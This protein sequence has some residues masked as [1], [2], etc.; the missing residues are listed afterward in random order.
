MMHPR[1]FAGRSWSDAE[2]RLLRFAGPEQ[3]KGPEDDVTKLR[4]DLEAEKAKSRGYEQQIL[5]MRTRMDSLE[6]TV[7]RVPS[8]MPAL[9][10][11]VS[12]RVAY[13]GAVDHVLTHIDPAPM[14]GYGMRY[15]NGV[16]Y[17]A[18][19]GSSRDSWQQLK[20]MAQVRDNLRRERTARHTW[21]RDQRT[22][23]RFSPNLPM[24]GVSGDEYLGRTFD[25]LDRRHEA[26]RPGFRSPGEGHFAA[27]ALYASAR[28]DYVRV[29]SNSS[30]YIDRTGKDRA[31]YAEFGGD[32]LEA[33]GSYYGVGSGNYGPRGPGGG[34][35]IAYP[36]GY[37]RQ[38]KIDPADYGVRGGDVSWADRGG[39]NYASY[40]YPSRYSPA[41]PGGDMQRYMRTQSRLRESY[42]DDIEGEYMGDLASGKLR[43][44]LGGD[45]GWA[46]LEKAMLRASSQ[47]GRDP[48]RR[49]GD[50][51]ILRSQVGEMNRRDSQRSQ[52]EG[53]IL[54][55]RHAAE[56]Y[57]FK[58]DEA[59]SPSDMPRVEPEVTGVFRSFDLNPQSLFFN[60][61]EK[62]SII[63]PADVLGTQKD[64]A[65]Q[66]DPGVWNGDLSDEQFAALKRGGIAIERHESD[67]ATYAQGSSR[68]PKVEKLTVY[69][70]KSGTFKLNGMP[71]DIPRNPLYKGPKTPGRAAG[72]APQRRGNVPGTFSPSAPRPNEEPVPPTVEVP[73]PGRTPPTV[74]T[75]PP[76]PRVEPE[77]VPPND[78]VFADWLAVNESLLG[79][80][81]MLIL[82][83]KNHAALVASGALPKS[84]TY[85][86]TQP[87][88]LS[89]NGSRWKLGEIPLLQRPG[90]PAVPPRIILEKEGDPLVFSGLDD[91]T[92]LSLPTLTAA[93]TRA[94]QNRASEE[95]DAAGI[96]DFDVAG[97]NEKIGL[98]ELHDSTDPLIKK[99]HAWT[100]GHT[101]MMLKRYKVAAADSIDYATSSP[102]ALTNAVLARYKAGIRNFH[103]NVLAHGNVGGA[104]FGGKVIAP[105]QFRDI[106]VTFPDA[107]FTLNVTSCYGAGLAPMMRQYVD[108]A[109]AAP[110]RVTVFTQSKEDVVNT[111]TNISD[112][113]SISVY[114]AAMSKYLM[115]GVDGRQGK[116]LT[117]GEAHL[118][119]DRDAKL[120]RRNDAEVHTS[121]PGAPSR[122]TAG[123]DGPERGTRT[124]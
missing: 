119:A 94:V 60:R 86:A 21:I 10:D 17:R 92:P 32:P 55:I 24:G 79:P 97:E 16:V 53:M 61:G 112:N 62:T 14:P 45:P 116:R 98:I 23:A 114:D 4:A 118:L 49:Y 13:R 102:G 121:S 76:N 63:I 80:R 34:R 35:S 29:E 108:L 15:E 90:K 100:I 101:L 11:N 31:H 42:A 67:T 64:Y 40:N 30:M 27:Q 91:G 3:P 99:E 8:T 48:S 71:V 33:R 82:S 56:E 20:T 83:K 87:T 25:A 105:S 43:K 44:K 26:G 88:L 59:P 22:K 9:P 111:S 96:K 81:S 52:Q 1:T 54:K 6:Q 113:L 37:D 7:R 120:A 66:Y 93:A 70:T 106:F 28:G 41:A 57:S 124:V 123:T 69:F 77:V 109:S 19:P 68:V 122:R 39:K 2:R 47:W 115:Q 18:R 104:S 75:P 107:K 110:S 38:G 78:K 46:S 65:V 95:A 117:Y 73:P 50:L 36:Y 12:P 85:D 89:L 5:E 58:S 103:I 51:A 74:D 84:A 72:L